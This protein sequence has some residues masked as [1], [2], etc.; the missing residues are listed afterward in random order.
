MRNRIFGPPLIA[1]ALCLFGGCATVHRTVGADGA[2]TLQYAT[3]MQAPALTTHQVTAEAA[4]RAAAEGECLTFQQ[5]TRGGTTSLRTGGMECNL[6]GGFV[7]GV[8]FTGY[9]PGEAEAIAARGNGLVGPP[10]PPS[11]PSPPMAAT[12]TTDPAIAKRVLELEAAQRAQAAAIE[13][14]RQDTDAVLDV[15]LAPAP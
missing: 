8:G 13:G 11:T 14:V 9:R 6:V 3:A 2:V 10:A 12:S 5:T 1:A 15:V 4:A 7:G